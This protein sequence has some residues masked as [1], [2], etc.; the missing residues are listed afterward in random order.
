MKVIVGGCS[1]SDYTGAEVDRVYGEILSER[2][3]AEYI[4]HGSGC[5][6]NYRMW[7]KITNLIMNGE[8]SDKDLIIMQYTEVVRDEFW[9]AEI[10][11]RKE[12]IY[13]GHGKIKLRETEH[14]GDIVKWKAFL[15]GVSLEEKQFFRLKEKYFTSIDFDLERF[16]YH[17]YMFHNM[18]TSKNI[19]VVYIVPTGYMGGYSKNKVEHFNKNGEIHISNNLHFDDTNSQYLL[20]DKCHF[21]QLGHEYVAE[22]LEIELRLLGIKNETI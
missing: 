22:T 5:G 3:N 18:V 10:Q 2:L 13:D 17:H 11:T 12:N 20:N 1:V 14:F 9:S 6:S 16:S 19:K 8:I 4:H 7:R 21:S 15:Y